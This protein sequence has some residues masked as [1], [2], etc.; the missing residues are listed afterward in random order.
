[1]QR[2]A[3]LRGALKKVIGRL[4]VRIAVR[5]SWQTKGGNIRTA[6][7]KA[8][9]PVWGASLFSLYPKKLGYLCS[10]PEARKGTSPADSVKKFAKS[11]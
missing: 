4:S 10:A 2:H 7:A 9:V 5:S 11:C 8:T 3:L 6:K 1:M